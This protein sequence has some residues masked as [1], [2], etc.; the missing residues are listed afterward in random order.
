MNDERR[1]TE[2]QKAQIV[3]NREKAFELQQKSKTISSPASSSSSSSMLRSVLTPA[4]Q[5]Q[6]EENRRKAMEKLKAKK[7]TPTRTDSP[8][9][10]GQVLSKIQVPNN[11]SS[12]PE[13]PKPPQQKLVVCNLEVCD[14]NRFVAKTDGYHEELINEFK[15]INSRSYSKLYK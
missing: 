11:Q 1:V 7:L 14:E 13:Q 6:I 2:E 15:K 9:R 3:T 10:I 5:A 8:T 12:K 4:Q